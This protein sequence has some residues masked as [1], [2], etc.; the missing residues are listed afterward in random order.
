MTRN[1]QIQNAAEIYTDCRD[2]ES[3]RIKIAFEQSAKWAD[4]NP[5]KDTNTKL[6]IAR[7][8]N[9]NLYVYSGKPTKNIN[10]GC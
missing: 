5:I 1:Q 2:T 6:Y 4:R 10:T 7:D 3:Q 8:K 9:G